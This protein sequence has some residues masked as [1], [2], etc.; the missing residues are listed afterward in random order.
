MKLLVDLLSTDSG[1]MSLAVIAIVLGMVAF[2]V[3]MFLKNVRE[4][5]AASS[6]K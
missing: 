4:E 5:D 6:A 2:F 3:R 1:L